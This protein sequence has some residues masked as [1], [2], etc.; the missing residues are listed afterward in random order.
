MVHTAPRQ[1]RARWASFWLV[2]F[3]LGIAA[4]PYFPFT[5][6]QSGYIT[7]YIK[8][9]LFIILY[10]YLA[11]EFN[12][13]ATRSS[14]DIWAFIKDNGLALIAI[15]VGFGSLLLLMLLP[16]YRLTPDQLHIMLQC[17]AAVAFDFF[18]GVV[19]SQRI[20]FAGKERDESPSTR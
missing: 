1:T 14:T 19:I 6:D 5:I 11:I 3:M 16:G 7:A 20:A 18:Y 8:Q 10:I 9:W 4:S 17:L 2:L 12:E 13:T 15:F